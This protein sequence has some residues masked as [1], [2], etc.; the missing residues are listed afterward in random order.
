MSMVVDVECQQQQNQQLMPTNPY[1]DW[2]M[3]GLIV[4][5]QSRKL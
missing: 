5:W 1:D 3:D 2:L 4:E